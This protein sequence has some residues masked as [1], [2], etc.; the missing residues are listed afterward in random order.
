MIFHFILNP[1]SGRSP[2]QVKLEQ[3][4]KSACMKRQ[5]SYHIYYTTAVGDA[6]EYVKS[7]IRI[8]QERQRFICVGGDGTINEI[9]NSAPSNPNVEFGVIPSGS[10]NDF[11]RNFTNTKLFSDIN[12]QIDG[13]TQ[14]FDLIKCNDFYCVNMVNIGFDCSV[15]KEAS[16]IKK[17]V[18]WLSPN[19]SYIFGV[20]AVLFKKFG[21]KMK[22]I[23]DDGEVVEKEFTLTAI[24][25]G[26][27]CGGGFMAQP[28]ALLNDGVMDICAIDKVTRLTFISLVSSYKKG[29]YLENKRALRYIKHKQVSHFKME[30]DAPIA[31]CIDGEIKGAKTVD[32]TVIPNALNF[33]IPKGSDMKYKNNG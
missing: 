13:E 9:A 14:S 6:T 19:L 8:S 20:V 12:A 26:K 16:K 4:I 1:K 7:M 28:R 21:T 22:L 31:I 24:G 3:A 23:Y 25:N 11:V 32:F 17:Y 27:F 33:V 5:L 10:G 29:T 15:V 30:F 2:K 18:K